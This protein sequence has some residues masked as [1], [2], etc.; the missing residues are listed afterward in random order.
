LTI[1]NTT[2]KP[3]Q[4]RKRKP[5]TEAERQQ[6]MA[7]RISRR[8]ERNRLAARRSRERK[9]QHMAELEDQL[10]EAADINARLRRKLMELGINPDD[11]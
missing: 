6:V 7:S 3:N 11:V 8:R 2:K 4:P 1:T 5:K 9:T 10:H